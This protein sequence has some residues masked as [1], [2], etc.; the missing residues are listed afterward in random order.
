MPRNCLR[1]DLVPGGL[2]KVW[3]EV[4]SSGSLEN[5]AGMF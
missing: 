5:F 3:S 4:R 2:D 1:V